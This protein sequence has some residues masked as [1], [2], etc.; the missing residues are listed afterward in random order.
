MTFCSI[1]KPF[2]WYHPCIINVPE[3]LLQLFDAIVPII[4][5]K[6]YFIY[7]FKKE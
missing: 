3:N 6:E 5:G 4:I 7:Y 2:I 1:I